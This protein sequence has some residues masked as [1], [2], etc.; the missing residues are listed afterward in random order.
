MG[1]QIEPSVWKI[2]FDWLVAETL[3][4]VCGA[5]FADPT[6]LDGRY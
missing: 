2:K 5:R 4:H 1:E 3:S 6:L